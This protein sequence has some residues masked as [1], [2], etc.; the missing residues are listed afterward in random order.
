MASVRVVVKVVVLGEP[1]TGKSSVVRR[2]VDGKFTASSK[3]SSAG[4]GIDFR[5]TSV[6]VV[7]QEYSYEIWDV[8]NWTLL[9]NLGT[10]FWR[11]ISGCVLV[12]DVTKASTFCIFDNL[13]RCV[14]SLV[15][16]EDFPLVVAGNMVDRDPSVRDVSSE[17]AQSWCQKV[18]ALYFEVS[19]VTGSGVNEM[20]LALAERAVLFYHHHHPSEQV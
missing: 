15:N 9:E 16:K 4:S 17:I 3:G 10:D 14:A 20:F 1:K 6:T 12:F 7:G 8:P 13:Y 2:Y 5:Q 11:D 19:A 18:G